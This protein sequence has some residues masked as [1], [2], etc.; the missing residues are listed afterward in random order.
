[1]NPSSINDCLVSLKGIRSQVHDQLDASTRV[2]LEDVIVRL[3]AALTEANPTTRLEDIESA[4]AIF[5]KVVETISN[6]T[7]LVSEFWK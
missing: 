4:L 2:E 6:V 7:D 3:E 5:A 1:M